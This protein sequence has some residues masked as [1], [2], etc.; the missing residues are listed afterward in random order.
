VGTLVHMADAAE[1]EIEYLRNRLK[2]AEGVIKQLSAGF[3]SELHRGPVYIHPA[4]WCEKKN[5]L[6]PWEIPLGRPGSGRTIGDVTYI[7]TPLMPQRTKNI[8]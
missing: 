5:S 2:D 4:D 3:Q 6:N 1:R 7:V 8:S